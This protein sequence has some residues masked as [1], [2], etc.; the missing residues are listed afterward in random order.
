MKRSPREFC[1]CRYRTR[2]RKGR[3]ELVRV[4]KGCHRHDPDPK[5]DLPDGVM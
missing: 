5:Y 3:V 2:V 1:T 4:V